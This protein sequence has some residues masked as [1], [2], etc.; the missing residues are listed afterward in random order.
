M[1]SCQGDEGPG[2]RKRRLGCQGQWDPGSRGA[3]VR[4]SEAQGMRAR[5]VAFRS[6]AGR[7]GMRALRVKLSNFFFSLFHKTIYDVREKKLKKKDDFPIRE[8]G[9]FAIKK[10][11]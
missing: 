7:R 4:V 1:S 8:Y 11:S 6:Y 2:S 5:V 9:P 3:E 10:N